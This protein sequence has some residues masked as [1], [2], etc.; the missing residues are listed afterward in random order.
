MN[1]EHSPKVL[2]R[3]EEAT[4]ILNWLNDGASSLMRA[5]IRIFFGQG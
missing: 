5:S 2:A 1:F 4:T 3:E